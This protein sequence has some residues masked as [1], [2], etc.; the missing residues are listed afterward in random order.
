MDSLQHTSLPFTW[1][2]DALRDKC[3]LKRS[4]RKLVKSS[5]I[6]AKDSLNVEKPGIFYSCQVMRINFRKDKLD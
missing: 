4:L 2:W 1:V 3:V 6:V 5:L